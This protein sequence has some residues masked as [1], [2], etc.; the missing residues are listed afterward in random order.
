MSEVLRRP[1]KHHKSKCHN[2]HHRQ[3]TS[4]NKKVKK[5]PVEHG[6]ATK[7]KIPEIKSKEK[8]VLRK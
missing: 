1:K 7:R 4:D 6:N 5:L 3:F 8:S 2:H